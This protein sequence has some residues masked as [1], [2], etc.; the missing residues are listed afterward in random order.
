MGRR[1]NT[2]EIIDDGSESIDEGPSKSAR[3]RAATAAQKL[4]ERLMGLRE[5]ELATLP[6]P[7][8]LADAIRAARSIRSHGGLARQ[9]QFIGKLMREVDPAPILEI[10]E[11][12]SRGQALDAE[13]FKRVEAWRDRLIKEGDAALTA[14]HDWRPLDAPVRAQ[15]AE[16]LGRARRS[17]ATEAQRAAAGRELF[18][19]LR[20]LFAKAPE[21]AAAMAAAATVPG[22]TSARAKI[23]PRVTISR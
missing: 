8:Q 9:R 15:L 1:T 5:A 19:S 7:E 23:S 10:L 17:S 18:R 2:D 21:P 6:L 13:R 16:Q 20:T 11:A 22:K 14:L 4:G 3:K 12:G